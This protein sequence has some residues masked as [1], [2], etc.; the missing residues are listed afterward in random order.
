MQNTINNPTD[1]L[2]FIKSELSL[3]VDISLETPFRNIAK[4]SSLNALIIISRIHEETG[5]I[6]SSSDLATMNTFGDIYHKIYPS[7]N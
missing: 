4:W 6:I 5:V 1:F 3:N 7:H 2:H